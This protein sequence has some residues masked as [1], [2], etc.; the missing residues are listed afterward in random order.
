MS[1]PNTKWRVNKLGMEKCCYAALVNEMYRR[2]HDKEEL[3]P[4]GDKVK[5]GIC[6]SEM[7][8]DLGTGDRLR[9][10]W[11]GSRS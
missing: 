9:W 8:C 6:G 5:C 1:T 3:M 7:I 10:R 2:T 11:N 4:E